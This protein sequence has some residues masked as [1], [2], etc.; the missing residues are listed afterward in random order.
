MKLINFFN[1]SKRPWIL[2]VCPFNLEI[3]MITLFDGDIFPIIEHILVCL[4]ILKICLDS[5]LSLLVCLSLLLLLNWGETI[6]TLAFHLFPDLATCNTWFF[7]L[8]VFPVSVTFHIYDSSWK[9]QAIYIFTHCWLPPLTNRMASLL[10][11]ISLQRNFQNQ[12]YVVRGRGR[13]WLQEGK[14]NI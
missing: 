8:N 11:R 1:R 12:G 7:S 6:K 9:P 2:N 4:H 14:G 10:P 13:E 5:H 3:F